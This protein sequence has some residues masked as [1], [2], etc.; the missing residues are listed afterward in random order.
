MLEGSVA[1]KEMLLEKFCADEIGI[2]RAFFIQAIDS[3]RDSE[4]VEKVLGFRVAV[5]IDRCLERL[6]IGVCRCQQE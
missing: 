1:G 5:C 6:H 4:L 2:G 3:V